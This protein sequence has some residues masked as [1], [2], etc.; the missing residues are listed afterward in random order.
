M[1]DKHVQLEPILDYIIFNY[2]QLIRYTSNT[3]TK[4]L[5]RPFWELYQAIML[6]FKEA[7]FISMLTIGLPASV[8]SIV[9]YCLCCLSNETLM[10]DT[11][12]LYETRGD[13]ETMEQNEE[14]NEA[15]MP[16]KFRQGKKMT[17]E[18]KED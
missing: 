6:M 4:H 16:A 2:S 18:K 8:L 13:D 15:D 1:I 11:D 14:D 9:C 7:P 5:I 10:T 12:I 3:W 17:T